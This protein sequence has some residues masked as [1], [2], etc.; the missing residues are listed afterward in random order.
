[1]PCSCKSQ[2]GLYFIFGLGLGLGL[3]VAGRRISPWV[4]QDTSLRSEEHVL[5]TA[6]QLICMTLP[7]SVPKNNLAHL[8]Y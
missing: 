7:R 6:R 3:E 8:V 5:A 2:L 1:M 4:S